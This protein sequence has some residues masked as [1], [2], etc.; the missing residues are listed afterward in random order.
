MKLLLIPWWLLP[1][2]AEAGDGARLHLGDPPVSE[3]TAVEGGVINADPFEGSSGRWRVMRRD[4]QLH[5][6][7]DRRRASSSSTQSLLVDVDGPAIQLTWSGAAQSR[8]DTTIV[9]PDTRPTVEVKDGSGVAQVRYVING[10]NTVSDLPRPLPADIN[11]IDVLA[12]DRLGNRARRTVNLLVDNDGPDI[13]IDVLSR[14]DNNP[15][16]SQFPAQLSI[17]MVDEHAEVVAA[18]PDVLTLATTQDLQWQEDSIM[19]SAVDAFGN[20][21]TEQRQWRYDT[22]GPV[23][24]VDYQ[25]VSYA[26]RETVHVRRGDSVTFSVTD[27]GAGLEQARYRYNRQTVR[28]LPQSLSFADRGSYD[29]RVFMVDKLGNESQQHWRVIAK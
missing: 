21:S 28:R 27:E 19:V 8:P 1:V 20:T 14:L 23:A 16:Y 26:H 13:R 6:Y 7:L 29:I 9:G 3:A 11:R 18:E 22:Q 12:T 2:S 15:E 10:A 4:G 25:G 24:R 5:W 17:S